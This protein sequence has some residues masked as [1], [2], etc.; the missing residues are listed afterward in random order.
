[1]L[2]PL[3]DDD[4]GFP[5]TVKDLA[6]EQFVPKFCSEIPASRQ[7]GWADFPW[8]IVTSICRS[9]VM[10]CSELNLFFGMTKLLS[11]TGSNIPLGTKRDGQV[12]GVSYN[13]C[14]LEQDSWI[15]VGAWSLVS[16]ECQNAKRTSW[17]APQGGCG[18]PD[19]CQAVIF[20]MEFTLS[21][22][23]NRTGAP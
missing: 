12:N 5:E 23:R 9:S 8:P 4:L 11:K 15:H 13:A 6:I 19:L 7:A 16:H 3:L 17:R 10:I 21:R 22:G 1:V 2:A 14:T 20:A 18:R